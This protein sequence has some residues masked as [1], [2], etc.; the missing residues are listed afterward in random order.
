MSFNAVHTYQFSN[1]QKVDS[2]SDMGYT[3]LFTTSSGHLAQ[4]YRQFPDLVK[5]V[6][7]D[8]AS[9]RKC[10]EDP[11]CVKSPGHLVGVPSW[12]I[13]TFHFWAGPDH[14]LGSKWTLAP[15]NYRLNDPA[16][17]KANGNDNFYLGY[18]VERTCKQKAVVP[19]RDRPR[20]AYVFAKN[21]EYFYHTEYPWVGV[22]YDKPPF[23]V[24]FIAGIVF[25]NAPNGEG[26][27]PGIK[28]VGKLNRQQFYEKVGYSRVLIGIRHP[29]MSPSPYDAL[30]LGVPF[31]N[32][33]LGWDESDP[34][35]RQKWDTQHNGLK[36]HDIPYVYHVKAGD[37]QGFWDALRMAMET[38]ID[39]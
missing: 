1:A 15:E 34:E 21:E 32:P 28:D 12:K 17:D 22:E 3:L 19:F 27:P 13:V 26:L 18:S 16:G 38:P 29:I 25:R 24:D 23:D 33:V 7:L 5:I 2:I 35:N 36:F 9:A 11:R 14:P 4:T 6:I 37:V 10:F 30:C 31:I 8:E 39:R 20:Q